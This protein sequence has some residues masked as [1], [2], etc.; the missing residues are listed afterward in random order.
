MPLLDRVDLDAE[1][2]GQPAA[3]G[4][5]ERL[6]VDHYLPALSATY[7]ATAL[8]WASVSTPLKAGMTPPPWMT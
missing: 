2:P 4:L 7:L 3:A 8:I 1:Q 5:D 6:Q